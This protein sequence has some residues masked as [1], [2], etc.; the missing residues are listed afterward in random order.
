M[1]YLGLFPSK[2][3]FSVSMKTEWT[4]STMS[5]KLS[6]SK[7]KLQSLNLFAAILLVSRLRKSWAL[8]CASYTHLRH[9]AQAQGHSSLSFKITKSYL[10]LKR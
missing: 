10:G 2:V 3:R 7:G 4:K 9:G 8:S 5:N 6:F 1:R